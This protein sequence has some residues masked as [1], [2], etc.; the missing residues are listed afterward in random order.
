M[1]VTD[2][3][4]KQI[5]THVLLVSISYQNHRI[6]MSK[7]YVI[8]SWNILWILINLFKKA[9]KKGKMMEK[10]YIKRIIFRFMMFGTLS[11]VTPF[12]SIIFRTCIMISCLRASLCLNVKIRY[13]FIHKRVT[14]GCL[15]LISTDKTRQTRSM[16]LNSCRKAKV[17]QK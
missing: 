13:N 5:V 6:L 2:I 4:S 7:S 1:N 16:H 17:I 10:S 12:Y 15:Y 3:N 9:R 11:Y 8:A 14:S